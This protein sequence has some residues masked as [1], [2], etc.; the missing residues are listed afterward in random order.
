[1]KRRVRQSM[2]AAEIVAAVGVVPLQTDEDRSQLR[3]TLAE[4]GLDPLD[5]LRARIAVKAGRRARFPT[6]L[7]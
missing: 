1:M 4:L 3:V 6:R 7:D 2:T 5:L